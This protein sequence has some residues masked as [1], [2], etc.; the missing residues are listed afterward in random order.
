MKRRFVAFICT[1]FIAVSTIFP[2]GAL[3]S[4]VISQLHVVKYSVEPYASAYL[5]DYSIGFGARD[6]CRMVVTMDVNGVRT[7]DKIGCQMLIIEHKIN[8]VWYEYDTQLGIDHPDFYMYNT[9]SYLGGY[10]FYGEAGVQYRV[11]MIA[12]AQNSTGYDTG[13]VTSYVITCR[14]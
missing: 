9:P 8:G 13:E 4:P 5:S 10:E 12:L 2:I 3:E 7:M 6:N 11:T 14:E 1:T